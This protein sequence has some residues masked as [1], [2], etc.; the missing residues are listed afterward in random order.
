MQPQK[1]PNSKTIAL[2]C[3]VSALTLKEWHK[4]GKVGLGEGQLYGKW[5]S[6]G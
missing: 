6:K 2:S 4:S 3:Q 1:Y 5:A